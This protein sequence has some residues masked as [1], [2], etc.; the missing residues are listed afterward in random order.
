MLKKSYRTSLSLWAMRRI[1]SVT[2]ESDEGTGEVPPLTTPPF[3]LLLP[4]S[5][6]RLRARRDK[7][8]SLKDR[9]L[10]TRVLISEA[11]KKHI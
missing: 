6:D 8:S 2:S 5:L 3:L 11:K 4:S 1:G 10:F 9:H 7:M